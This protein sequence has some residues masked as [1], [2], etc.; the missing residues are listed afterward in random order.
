[1]SPS[2][3]YCRLSPAAGSAARP[4]RTYMT[5]IFVW[6]PY[7]SCFNGAISRPLESATMTPSAN[8]LNFAFLGVLFKISLRREEEKNDMIFDQMMLSTQYH[9]NPMVMICGCSLFNKS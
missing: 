4:S 9:L 7:T 8:N 1:M 6:L 2:S 5:Y 3:V